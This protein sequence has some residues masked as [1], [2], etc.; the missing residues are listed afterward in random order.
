[1][2]LKNSEFRTIEKFC[3]CCGNKLKLNNNRDIE[4]KKFCSKSCNATYLLKKL[5]QNKEYINIMKEAS[6]KPNPKKG[7]SGENHPK[8]IKD[9]TKLKAKKITWEQM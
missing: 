7:H 3:S 4:C 8:W 2:S 6:S 5:W 1:M 9:R